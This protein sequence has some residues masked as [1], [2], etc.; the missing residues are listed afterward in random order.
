MKIRYGFVSNSSSSSYIITIRN[1][2]RSSINFL[3]MFKLI[4]PDISDCIYKTFN[5]TGFVLPWINTPLRKAFTT[6]RWEKWTIKPGINKF[7]NSIYNEDYIDKTGRNDIIT[8]MVKCHDPKKRFEWHIQ[9]LGQNEEDEQTEK[10]KISKMYRK[11][12]NN[13]KKLKRKIIKRKTCSCK[14]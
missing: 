5:K 13:I 1:N 12:K 4:Y 14:K 8:M 11:R 6:T 9:Y 2:T 3:D 10:Y 7:K